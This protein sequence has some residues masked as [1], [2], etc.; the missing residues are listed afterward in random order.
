MNEK[1]HTLLVIDSQPQTQ[2]ILE[3]VLSPDNFR[4]IACASGHEALQLSISTK[5][6][7]VLLDVNLSDM[8]GV[9][10]IT[11]LRE[12]TSAPIIILTER[13]DNEAVVGALNAGAADYVLKPFSMDVLAARINANLR[14][15]ALQESGEAEL[16]NGPLR[17]DLMRHQ[18]WLDDTL[19]SFTPKEYDLLKYMVVYKGKMLLH[20]QILKEVWGQSHGEDTQYLR[21]FIGQLRKKI[22]L[23]PATPVMITTEPG[24]GYRMEVMQK[25]T[26][27]S[28]QGEFS[29]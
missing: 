6:D 20:K 18:V 17:I 15:S 12:W 26:P 9:C 8:D 27:P 4:L 29:V 13:S 10:L 24:I 21:V 23:N 2:K 3:L 19:I 25:D 7:L 28:A 22:E 1:K 11:Q 16:T 5:P 14:Q